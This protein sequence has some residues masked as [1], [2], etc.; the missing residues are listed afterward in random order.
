MQ[1]LFSNVGR[2]KF[3]N[4]DFQVLGDTKLHIVNYNIEHLRKEF[5]SLCSSKR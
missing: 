5:P 2:S 3:I 1:S 4:S